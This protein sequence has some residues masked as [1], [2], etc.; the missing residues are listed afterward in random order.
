MDTD[1]VH[2]QTFISAI[3]E[4]NLS[5]SPGDPESWSLLSPLGDLDLTPQIVSEDAVEYRSTS[6]V[7]VQCYTSELLRSE[8]SGQ[9]TFVLVWNVQ[10]EA[11]WQGLAPAAC[12]KLGWQGA[13]PGRAAMTWVWSTSVWAGSLAQPGL[14]SVHQLSP[15]TVR[16]K[17]LRGLLTSACTSLSQAGEY[18]AH[19]NISEPCILITWF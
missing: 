10:P 14:L 15:N 4:R 3:T 8:T 12:Q 9:E 7:W 19:S 17:W 18:W 11:C 1:G 13:T 6:L 5:V 2:M 16:A